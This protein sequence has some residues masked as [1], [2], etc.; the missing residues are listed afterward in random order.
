LDARTSYGGKIVGT[1]ASIPI[2]DR[3]SESSSGA[4]FLLAQ[5]SHVSETVYVAQDSSLE[6]RTGVEYAV[7]RFCGAG[8]P[9]E[10]LALGHKLVQQGLDLVSILGK[11][12][13]TLR[14]SADE[15]LVWWREQGKQVLRV[16]STATLSFDVPPVQMTVHHQDGNEVVQPEVKPVYHHAFRY[17]RLSQITE[18]LYDAYR[19]M[20]LAFELLLSSK[21][22]R[23]NREREIDW[24]QRGI[25]QADSVLNLSS[26]VSSSA[27]DTVQAIVKTIY[28]DARL[29][30]FHA[31]EGRDFYLPQSSHHHQAVLQALQLLT[32]MVLRMSELWYQARYLGGGV[33]RGWVYRS[34]EDL[35]SRS[36]MLMS[37]DA[38]EFDPSQSDLGHE[39]YKT[40]VWLDVELVPSP[41]GT[42]KG[43]AL[44][45][46][47][48]DEG[49]DPSASVRRFEVVGAKAPRIAH[50]LKEALTLAGIDQLE[51]RFDTR[52]SNIRQPRYLFAR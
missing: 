50:I 52:V 42:D 40:A 27:T 37:D 11:D 38:S 23:G 17:F 13:L 22:P 5:A 41:S 15:Y 30:L 14:D 4:A 35:L 1:L 24:L 46:R 51:C 25:A 28:Y 45:G 44:L 33:T 49:F 3:T 36:R 31:K 32:K 43:P 39:R 48:S 16:V 2:A 18:D 21:Y 29:P 10:A 34:I 26:L 19:N 20:Y 8:S 7:A 6:L 9:Q 47:I 12:D